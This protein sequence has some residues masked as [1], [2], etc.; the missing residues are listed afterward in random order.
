MKRVVLAVLALGFG[1]LAGGCQ[2][3]GNGELVY[4]ETISPNESY[5]T[6]QADIVYYTVQVYQD[7]HNQITVETQSN[8]GFF[9]PVEYTVD[10]D[11]P[12]SEE[13]VAVEWTTMMG[14]PDPSA[15]DQ[16]GVA[17]ISLSWEGEVFSESKVNFLNGGLQ[18]IADHYN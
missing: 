5:V 14:S 13:N 17:D 11:N 4:E 3:S 7:S 16:L 8:S 15:E 12:I 10:F 6:D 1:I 9:D 2:A 18:M